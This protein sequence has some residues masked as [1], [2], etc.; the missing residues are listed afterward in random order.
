MRIE[1]LHI[2]RF[3]GIA[4]AEIK[5]EGDDAGGGMT[6][7]DGNCG[8][9]VLDAVQIAAGTFLYWMPMV[10]GCKFRLDDGEYPGGSATFTDPKAAEPMMIS[11]RGFFASDGRFLTTVRD[12][13]A[14]KKFADDCR[15][16]RLYDYSDVL[17]L[18]VFNGAWRVWDWR[19]RFSEPGSWLQKADRLRVPP[20]RPLESICAV[21]HRLVFHDGRPSD[22][23]KTRELPLQSGHPRADQKF[24]QDY[25]RRSGQ[26][27]APDRLGGA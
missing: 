23:E 8:R 18:F 11:R 5:F 9:K 17:P 13:T 24:S 19:C 10:K 4:D 3:R 7:L 25:A 6:L 15:R 27:P 21:A 22:K 26:M 20:G 12:A 2:N 16:R 14:L 1:K